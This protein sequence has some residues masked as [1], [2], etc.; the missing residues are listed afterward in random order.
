[1]KTTFMIAALAAAMV[2][3]PVLA[4]DPAPAAAAAY[5]VEAT[6][7]G[8]LIDNPATKAILDKNLPGFSANPQIAM[9]RGMTL[10]QVQGFAPDQVSEAQLA[11]IDT[12]LKAL[13]SAK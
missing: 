2:S 1:M 7:I 11:Q 6:D 4:A 5:S 13:A 12:E 3:A 8:T 9:A 10:K